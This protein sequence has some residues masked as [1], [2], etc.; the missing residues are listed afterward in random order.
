MR[1]LQ[2]CK[3]TFGD[4][5]LQKTKLLTPWYMCFKFIIIRDKGLKKNNDRLTVVRN[6]M[7][8]NSIVKPN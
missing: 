6:M 1:L 7:A 2:N 4:Q 5:F 8:E 3:Y